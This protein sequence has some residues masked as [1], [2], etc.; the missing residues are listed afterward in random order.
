[1]WLW[2]HPSTF[3]RDTATEA[4]VT[5]IK[6]LGPERIVHYLRCY[7]LYIHKHKQQVTI[8]FVTLN[9][10]DG[11]DIRLLGSACLGCCV[12]MPQK[13]GTI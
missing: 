3:V 4:S 11:T 1:M 13:S 6:G 12:L 5:S 9:H 2:H 10:L 7:V 8:N